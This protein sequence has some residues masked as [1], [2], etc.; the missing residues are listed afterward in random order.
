MN[1]NSSELVIIFYKRI[2]GAD[3]Q[4]PYSVEISF[5]HVLDQLFHLLFSALPEVFRR[6]LFPR[7]WSKIWLVFVFFVLVKFSVFVPGCVRHFKEK[8]PVR[9]LS[10]LSVKGKLTI[11]I[12]TNLT[13]NDFFP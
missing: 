13:V 6:S 2:G 8:F 5:F 9:T 1:E 3:F 7:F 4:Q 11:N 12:F 10:V